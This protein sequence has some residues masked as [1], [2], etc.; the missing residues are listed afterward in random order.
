MLQ[1]Q[2]AFFRVVE[3]QLYYRIPVRRPT[4][5]VACLTAAFI[6]LRS[7][8]ITTR[9]GSVIS[10]LAPTV[11]HFTRYHRIVCS[12]SG[13]AR[14]KKGA[15]SQKLACKPLACLAALSCF[16]IVSFNLQRAASVDVDDVRLFARPPD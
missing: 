8:R 5:V 6:P 1:E 14:A 13:T 2:A 7:P 4:P 9:I 11:P 15:V 16:V 12:L 3:Y 10:L